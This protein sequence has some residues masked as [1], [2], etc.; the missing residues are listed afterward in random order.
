MAVKARRENERLLPEFVFKQ[1]PIFINGF[2]FLLFL[3]VD[4]F[5]ESCTGLEDRKLRCR[6]LDRFARLRVTALAS[7]ALRD[8]ERAELEERYRIV[9]LQ[10][11][12]DCSESCSE[13]CISLFLRRAGFL[14]DSLD[15]ICFLQKNPHFRFV[16]ARGSRSSRA[17]YHEKVRCK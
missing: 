11:I 17:L 2:L 5:L 3:S 7:G 4:E 8:F 9:L 14:G 13:N 10:S 12:F 16:F 6:N 15:E 1:Q